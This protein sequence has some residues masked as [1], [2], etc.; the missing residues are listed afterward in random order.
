MT[1]ARNAAKE[2]A[3]GIVEIVNGVETGLGDVELDGA[4]AFEGK[5]ESDDGE[6]DVAAH[7]KKE[8]EEEDD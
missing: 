3:K 1:K 6:E 5:D 7:I 8:K 2:N 4:G